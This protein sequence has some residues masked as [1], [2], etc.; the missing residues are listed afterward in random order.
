MTRSLPSPRGNVFLDTSAAFSRSGRRI[1]LIGPSP[2]VCRIL[3]V[4]ALER[5][6]P[7]FN[8]LDEALA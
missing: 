2:A 6:I 4:L 7:T 1:A 5:L 8:T 3:S